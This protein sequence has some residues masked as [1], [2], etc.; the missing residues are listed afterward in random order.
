VREALRALG[1]PALAA[2]GELGCGRGGPGWPL[3]LAGLVFRNFISES[4]LSPQ[5]RAGGG[6]AAR[7]RQP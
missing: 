6:G 3:S 7:R 4:R 2:P 1:L 5:T